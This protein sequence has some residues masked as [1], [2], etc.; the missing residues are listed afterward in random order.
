MREDRETSARGTNACG[1]RWQDILRGTQHHQAEDQK[2]MHHMNLYE[3]KT[4]IVLKED[5]IA[6]KANELTYVKPFLTPV[7]LQGRII[8]TD[9]LYTQR[10]FCQDVLAAGADYLLVVKHNQPTLYEDLSLFLRASF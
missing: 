2:K 6:E 7:L 9:A 3:A 1:V 8:S 5:M 10:R 4:A